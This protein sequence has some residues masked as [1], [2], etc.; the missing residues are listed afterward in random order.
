MDK[1]R[2]GL[3]S[4]AS[5]NSKLIPVIRS[6]ERGEL[7]AIASRDQARA[8]SYA[9]QWQI[10]FAFGSYQAMLDSGKI[11]AVYISLPNHLHAEWTIKALHSGL[12]VLC[13]K[14]FALSLGE[15]DQMIEASH[16]SGKYLAEAFMYLHHVQAR[17]A[18][19][20]IQDGRIGE[21]QAIWGV[22][23]FQIE[24]HSDIR[25]NPEFGGGSLWDVG[26][27]PVSFSQYIY[28]SPP[29]KVF[30][31]QLLCDSGADTLFAGAMY[32]HNS[33]IAQFTTSFYSPFYTFAEIIGTK[34]RMT[35][36]RPF[37]MHNKECHLLYFDQT[38]DPQEIEL[39]SQD[40]YLG[41]VEDMHNAILSDTP[42]ALSLAESRNHIRTILALYK[43]ARTGQPVSLD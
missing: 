27:Y 29:E 40:L 35:L 42:P 16:D 2:W 24:N 13:E 15:V 39:P 10:P 19:K 3:L 14:P 34:G 32:Y 11:D 18:K 22:F 33:S 30:G 41:E 4:T 37:N 8:K 7:V 1:V 21:I 26:V 38:G 36:V 17:V 9:E 31:I 6:S 20:W 43:S 25:L 5:I 28:G 12:H 23:T